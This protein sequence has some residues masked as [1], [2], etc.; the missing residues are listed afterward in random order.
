[1]PDIFILSADLKRTK[2]TETSKLVE[3]I[4]N[5]LKPMKD[6]IDE[7]KFEVGLI[8]EDI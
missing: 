5:S 4:Q 6:T 3:A 8:K 1:M 2:V 7:T